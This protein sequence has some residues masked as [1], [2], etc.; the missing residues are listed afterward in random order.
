MSEFGE[1]SSPV[2][3]RDD[4]R[5]LDHGSVKALKPRQS[6]WANLVFLTLGSSEK[7]KYL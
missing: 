1:R 5:Q 6:S 2:E 7:N 4:Y 3:P